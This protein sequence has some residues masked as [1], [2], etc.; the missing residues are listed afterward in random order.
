M[1]G[2]FASTLFFNVIAWAL[3][4]VFV[5]LVATGVNAK[6]K[7]IAFTPKARKARMIGYGVT[8]V[9]AFVFLNGGMV[10]LG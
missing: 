3:I 10:L 4:A 8:V 7:R 1:I 9:G 5:V 2:F 6:M